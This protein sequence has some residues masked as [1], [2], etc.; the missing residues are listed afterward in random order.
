MTSA[1]LRAHSKRA[2]S[3]QQTSQVSCY[4]DLP[5]PTIV[6]EEFCWWKSKWQL[7]VPKVD[8]PDTIVKSLKKSHQAALPNIYTILQVFCHTSIGLMF[9]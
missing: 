5:N 4:Y 8:C 9:L 7:L 3:N 6:D 2:A 1:R